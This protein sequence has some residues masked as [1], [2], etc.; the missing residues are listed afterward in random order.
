MDVNTL[1]KGHIIGWAPPASTPASKPSKN[2]KK[3]AKRREKQRELGK[4]PD[5]WE[6]DDDDESGPQ[7]QGSTT[8]LANSSTT[9]TTTDLPAEDKD[10][11]VSPADVEDDLSS[12][13]DKLNVK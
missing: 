7:D 9:I 1:P 5:N 3:K 10:Q 4:V 12:N 6:E 11:P 13:L 2:A 8:P